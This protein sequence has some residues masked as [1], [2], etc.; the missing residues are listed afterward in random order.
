MVHFSLL[1][2]KIFWCLS[3]LRKREK[4]SRGGE[5]REGERESQQAPYSTW[6]TTQ[7]LISHE[8]EI[9]T[10]AKIESEKLNWLSHWGTPHSYL[11]LNGACSFCDSNLLN[12]GDWGAFGKSA[13]AVSSQ[14]FVIGTPSWGC[15]S[16][17]AEQEFG[18]PHKI[19]IPRSFLLSACINKQARCM[20]SFLWRHSFMIA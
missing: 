2:K 19:G 7:D 8:H 20:F 1:L 17:P 15:S 13:G 4:V 3:I 9:M 16:F 11:V 18:L 5:E 12:V 14:H 6:S 10:W